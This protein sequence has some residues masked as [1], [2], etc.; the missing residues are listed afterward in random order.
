MFNAK[1]GSRT[2][3]ENGSGLTGCIHGDRKD[4]IKWDVLVIGLGH[5]KGS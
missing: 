2:L 3:G 5:E 1:T 4:C